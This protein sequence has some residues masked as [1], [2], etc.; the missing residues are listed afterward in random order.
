MHVIWLVY[1]TKFLAG[2][3]GITDDEIAVVTIEKDTSKNGDNSIETIIIQDPSK[4]VWDVLHLLGVPIALA[5]FGAWFQKSQQEQSERA[6]KEQRA[7]DA[8][9]TRKEILQ[10]YFARISTLK[11]D[12]NV[13]NG[14]T[15]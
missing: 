2:V 8:D 13:F 15:N 9:E 10:L 4:T 5:V 11:N 12:K 6:V 1:D 3:W 7:K 14:F